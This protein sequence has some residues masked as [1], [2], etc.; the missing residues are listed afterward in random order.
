MNNII[1]KTYIISDQ[2][3]DYVNKK[4]EVGT[5]RWSIVNLDI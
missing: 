2:K 1:N 3:S 4:L 5:L